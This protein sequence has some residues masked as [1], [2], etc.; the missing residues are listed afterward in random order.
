[1]RRFL[2]LAA[3][4]VLTSSL[5]MQGCSP[6]TDKAATPANEL[7]M[8]EQLLSQDVQLTEQLCRNQ[9]AMHLQQTMPLLSGAN[10]DQAKTRLQD[11]ARSLPQMGKLLW[12]PKGTRTD[13]A[14]TVGKLEQDAEK[15][16]RPFIE[17][18]KKAAEQ[19][20]TFYSP[21]IDTAQ[22]PYT[23]LGIPS[24]DKS[25]ILVAV[26]KQ[27]ILQQVASHQRKNLRLEPFPNQPKWKIETVE[28]ETLQQKQVDHPEKN[29][30]TSHYERDEVVVKFR[31]PPSDKE[32]KQIQQ[33]LHAKVIRK[34]GYSYIFESEHKEAK[35]LM[36]YF[37][38]WNVEYVEPHYI[39]VTNEKLKP[40]S[41]SLFP[42]P[43]RQNPKEMTEEPVAAENIPNDTLYKQYQWNLPLIETESSWSYNKGS[44]DLIVAVVDTGVDLNHPD[45]KGHLVPGTNIV[46]PDQPPQDD[47]G[48]GTHVAGVI[49]AETN[50]QLGVAGMSWY[51]CIMPVKVLDSSGAGSTYAVAQGIIWAAD[52]GAKVINLSLGNYA[53]SMFLHDAIRYAYDKDVVL[54]AASGNDNTEQP[55]YPAAYPEVLAVSATDSQKLKAAFSNYGDY[56][57]VAAPGVSIASTYPS[58]QYAALSGTS[59]ATPH[60]AGLAGLIRATNPK[61][62]N[63]Q[64]MNIMRK[65][66][67]DIGTP[68]KDTYFGYGLID[69]GK[70]VRA[71]YE[72]SK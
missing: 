68:G 7:K 32:I 59:M 23:V 21:R 10:R 67:K 1:M 46:N 25:H 52:H 40:S 61:L 19:G 37:K 33:D 41:F 16:T 63:V 44:K 29:A 27:N 24:S 11:M 3:A 69:V 15:Q 66:A 49:S 54:I 48:H 4:T 12:T 58:N 45:L 60:V 56:I 36:D 62:T 70:A 20:E 18:A 51:N 8:K 28:S 57:D 39:Y 34:I 42:W 47:V 50:N 14:I 35:Q 26:V 55:G 2:S 9:C 64:V 72:S 38:A 65:T 30:G 71:A 6:G 13:Q 43:F 31:R 53:S 17:K 22:G 5:L